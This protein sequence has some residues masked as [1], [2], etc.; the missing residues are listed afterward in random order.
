MELETEF[1][2]LDVNSVSAMSENTENKT[3]FVNNIYI[4]S[5][6]IYDTFIYTAKGINI[7]YTGNTLYEVGDTILV[8]DKYKV[9]I[10]DH[11]LDYSG[12]LKGTIKGV[13]IDG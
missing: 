8:D 13:L 10:V 6:T 1:L 11:N 9:F 7:K 12:G 5:P 3:K 2:G 4:Q